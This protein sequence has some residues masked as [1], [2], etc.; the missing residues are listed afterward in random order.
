MAS[1]VGDHGNNCC[2]AL[3]RGFE[4]IRAASS[5]KRAAY[6]TDVSATC[7]GKQSRRDRRYNNRRQ[8]DVCGVRV[9]DGYETL[10]DVF[11]ENAHTEARDARC[12]HVGELKR[13]IFSRHYQREVHTGL[14][15]RGH[16]PRQ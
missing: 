14:G 3:T 9:H 6:D 1:L 4:R 10:H 15:Q 7:E 12:P 16:F 11:E 13:S 8:D 5:D 2:C